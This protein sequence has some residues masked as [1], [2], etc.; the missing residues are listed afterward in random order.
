MAVARPPPTELLQSAWLPVIVA[1]VRRLIPALSRDLSLT[2]WYRDPIHNHSVGGDPH[3]QHLVALATDWA[4]PPDAL[5]QLVELARLQGLHPVARRGYVHVQAF[6]AG[7]LG[8]IGVE[9]PTV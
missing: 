5:D 8:R 2:S 7:A 1:Y 9:F 3:S 4:G 6:P